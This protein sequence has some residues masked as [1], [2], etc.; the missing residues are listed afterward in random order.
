MYLEIIIENT[1]L[2]SNVNSDISFK[3][4]LLNTILACYIFTYSQQKKIIS[5]L[6]DI[7]TWKE[8]QAISKC[9]SITLSLLLL[10][11]SKMQ[12]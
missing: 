8:M 5:R 4:A 12:T 11:L 1:F 7:S 9:Y 6:D 10:T 2:S 3:R